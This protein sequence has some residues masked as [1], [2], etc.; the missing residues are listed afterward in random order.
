MGIPLNSLRQA[1]LGWLLPLLLGLLAPGLRA[2]A[3][4]TQPELSEFPAGAAR[5]AGRHIELVSDLPLSDELR[6]LP[7]VFDAAM[8]QWQAMFQLS[9]AEVANW[10]VQAMLMLDR[11]RFIDAGLLP[12]HLAHFRHGFQLGDRLWI[13]EQA[14]GYYRR[15]LLLHEGT[16]WIM[17]RKYGRQAPPWLMEGMAEWFGTHRWDG[18]RLEVGIIPAAR[19]EVPYWGRVKIIQEQLA[20]GIAPSLESILRYNDTAHQQDDAYAWSWAAIVFLKQHPDTQATFK[21]LLEQALQSRDDSNRWLFGQLSRTW[22]RLR[23]Q[24][25]ATLPD[26]D[27]GFAPDRGLLCISDRPTALTAPHTVAVDSSRSW[28]ASGVVVQQGA[29]ITIQAQGEFVVGDQPQPW[30]CTAEGV[31]LEYHSGRPLGRLMMT[32]VA[33][34]VEEPQFSQPP[35]VMGVGSGGRFTMPRM[36]ELHFRINEASGDLADNRGSLSVTISP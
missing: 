11:Q 4:E 8:P 21:R 1:L 23:Q 15:H 33:P 25:S 26:F 12:A 7:A 19:E 34:I 13:S 27:Y 17:T 32:V 22:P 14:S 28:Q 18:Q 16:H 29:Q 3:A 31:T 10:R 2:T 5:V 6:E 20:E 35:P 36:G 9:Q 24:W 30:R